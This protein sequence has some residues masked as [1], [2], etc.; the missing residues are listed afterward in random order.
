MS[1][2]PADM[3]P[4]DVDKIPYVALDNAS[5]WEVIS[6][7]TL[8]NAGKFNYELLLYYYNQHLVML[9]D[10]RHLTYMSHL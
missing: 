10:E 2:A 3:G 5:G 4:P 8:E 7:G 9:S 6:S 1:L